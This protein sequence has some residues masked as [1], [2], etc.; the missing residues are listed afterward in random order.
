MSIQRTIIGIDLAWGNKRPDGYCVIEFRDGSAIY[1]EHGL[2]RGDAALLELIQLNPKE[3][4]LLAIDA[5][6]IIPNEEGS[7]PVDRET[8]QHFRKQHAAAHP[9]NRKLCPRPVR[10]AELLQKNDFQ[11]TWDLSHSHLAMEVF[12]H[13]ATVRWFKLNQIIK[14]KRG[15]VAEKK[16]AFSLLQTH[17]TTFINSWKPFPLSSALKKLLSREWTKDIEDQ[18][19]ALICALIGLWHQ[20]YAGKKSQVLGDIEK[21]FIVIPSV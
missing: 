4:T 16:E 3:Q 1:R 21:G 6:L 8:H 11:L 2:V 20:Q 10:T 9:A 14:Y 15:R 13:P 12:P 7:R 17:L 5:P 19:D 18:T